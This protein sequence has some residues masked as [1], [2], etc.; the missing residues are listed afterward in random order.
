MALVARLVFPSLQHDVHSVNIGP[1]QSNIDDKTWP[2]CDWQVAT[3][4]SR[5]DPIRIEA[6][7]CIKSVISVAPWE[8]LSSLLNS[9]HCR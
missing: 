2:P 6:K 3:M 4:G 5:S 9:H 7:K 1:V 8:L